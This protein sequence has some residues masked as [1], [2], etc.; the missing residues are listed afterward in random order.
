[1]KLKRKTRCKECPFRKGAP[2]GWLGPWTP[3]TILAQANSEAGLACHMD[4]K[5]KRRLTDDELVEKVHVCVGSMQY[6]NRTCKIYRNP[7][8][9]EMRRAVGTAKDCMSFEFKAYHSK[10]PG[11]EGED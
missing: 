11:T 5:A 7:E 10:P 8:L 3:E 6:A 9:E 1:M 4:A 2:R